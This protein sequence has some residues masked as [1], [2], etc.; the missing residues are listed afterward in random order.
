MAPQKKT[1]KKSRDPYR[2]KRPIGAF[3]LF[4]ATHRADIKKANPDIIKAGDI[5]KALGKEW[6]EASTK[7]RAPFEKKAKKATEKY[8][9]A[10]EKYKKKLAKEAAP[11]RPASAFF[12]YLASRRAAIIKANPGFAV[13]E[14]AKALGQEWREASAKTKAPFEKKATAAKDKYAKAK[15]KWDKKQQEKQQ[16]QEA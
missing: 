11:K 15:A 3:F 7:T 2:P 1:K 12:L 10:M 13:T 4:S 6:R 9:K 8:K 14:V 5:A 16:P